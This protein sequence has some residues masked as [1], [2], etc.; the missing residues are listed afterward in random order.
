MLKTHG[1]LGDRYVLLDRIGRGGMGEIW[2][3]NDALLER[4]V[5]VKV[6]LPGLSE[7]AASAG[8]F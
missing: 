4:I 7:D 3:A 5:A 6:L 8:R 1:K 2:R